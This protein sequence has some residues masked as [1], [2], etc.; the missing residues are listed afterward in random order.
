MFFL[1]NTTIIYPSINN[2]INTK[3]NINI[4]INKLTTINNNNIKINDKIINALT[5]IKFNLQ[6][7]ILLN[8][9]IK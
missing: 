7:E 8:S 2:T 1:Y 4:T 9:F 6:S 5:L 3:L